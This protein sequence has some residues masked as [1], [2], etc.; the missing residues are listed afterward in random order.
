MRG[1]AI[2][3]VFAWRCHG[4]TPAYAGKRGSVQTKQVA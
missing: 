4:I 3:T 1:K 2:L